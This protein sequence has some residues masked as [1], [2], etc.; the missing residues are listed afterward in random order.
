MMMDDNNY[1][2]YFGTP[3]DNPVSY[4]LKSSYVQHGREH[5]AHHELQNVYLEK[6]HQQQ[7]RGT[8]SRAG[9]TVAPEYVQPI[10]KQYMTAVSDQEATSN[11]RA[12]YDCSPNDDVPV[13]DTDDGGYTDV[14]LDD[15]TSAT[16]RI[17]SSSTD[18]QVIVIQCE[19][20]AHVDEEDKHPSCLSR[21]CVRLFSA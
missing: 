2:A 11:Y 16:C 19:A 20:V 17:S 15:D 10:T 14:N 7:K 21:L 1:Q 8:I 6:Q 4:P 12:S 18:P 13:F 5:G 3:H 9:W